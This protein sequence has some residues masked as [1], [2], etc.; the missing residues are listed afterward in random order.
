MAK[1]RGKRPGKRPRRTVVRRRTGRPI[2]RRKP[3]RIVRKPK[4][5]RRGPARKPTRVR[6][7]PAPA[8]RLVERT[9]YRDKRGHLVKRGTKGA[10]KFVYTYQVDQRGRVVRTIEKLTP[11]VM[12]KTA[13]VDRSG[14][15][16]G[17]LDW[18]LVKSSATSV[19]GRGGVSLIEVTLKARDERGKERRF[20]FVMDLEGVK[21]KRKLYEAIVGRMLD[22]LRGNGYRTNYTI[23]L[24]KQARAKGLKYPVT[25]DEWRDL[26]PLFDMEMIVTIFR[27]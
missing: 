24:F 16:M 4:A 5:P 23:Q 20:K 11:E 14:R 9:V 1:R 21:R 18:A 2:R 6:K 22:L 10:R 27:R 12:V 8:L 26:K 13:D 15:D 19:I 7:A 3:T 25:W 17:R